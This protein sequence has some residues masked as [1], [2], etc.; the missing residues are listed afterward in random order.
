MSL[1]ARL[2]LRAPSGPDPWPRRP[3]A[4][5]AEHRPHPAL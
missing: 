5:A 2:L 1:G 4:V 3:T